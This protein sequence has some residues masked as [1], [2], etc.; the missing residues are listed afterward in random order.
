M[1]SESHDSKDNCVHIF[2]N[3]DHPRDQLWNIRGTIMPALYSVASYIMEG[4]L[5]LQ[6]VEHTKLLLN[7]WTTLKKMP[8]GL[9]VSITQYHAIPN[10]ESTN[11]QF[12]F[13]KLVVCFNLLKIDFCFRIKMQ[14]YNCLFF[15]KWYTRDIGTTKIF[16]SLFF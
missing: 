5:S 4:Q 2:T 11:P 12:F 1:S 3:T 9:S 6:L 10:H 14:L 16:V 8:N 13:T 15:I 7:Y